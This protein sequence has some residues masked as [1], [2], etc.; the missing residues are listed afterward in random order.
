[1]VVTDAPTAWASS[2]AASSSP[3]G[4]MIASSS[5]ADAAEVVSPGS[6][7]LQS[8]S[9][10]VIFRPADERANCCPAAC[11]APARSVVPW[12]R[13][14]STSSTTLA[15]G[16]TASCDLTTTASRAKETTLK[17]S[18]ARN[19]T[20]AAATAFVASGRPLIDPL[21]S[22]S[23]HTAVR[24][25]TQRR[26]R[27]RSG[28]TAAPAAVASTSAS[29]L[30][31]MSRSPA[32]GSYRATSMRPT[33]RGRVGPRRATSSTNRPA[34]RRASSRSWRSVALVMSA[35]SPS[36]SSGSSA[37]NSSNAASSSAPSSGETRANSGLRSSSRRDVVDRRAS[38]IAAAAL[39]PSFRNGTPPSGP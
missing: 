37:I 14:A 5:N 29:P 3:A 12:P 34:R 24:G 21:R 22:T 30:A 18:G 16:T 28:S 6:V 25:C 31:S 27:S 11:S 32:S 17:S 20:A 15:D 7:A 13:R 38:S 9:S 35:R 33:P 1:M 2:V 4:A 26:T 23:R 36:A 10:T 19:A 39:G 8:D